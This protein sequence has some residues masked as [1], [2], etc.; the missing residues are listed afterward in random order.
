MDSE[1]GRNAAIAFAAEHGATLRELEEATGLSRMTVS[2][3]LAETRLKG[4]PER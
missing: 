4:A 2:R 1:R 3:I